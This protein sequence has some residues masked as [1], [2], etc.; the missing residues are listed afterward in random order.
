M[1]NFYGISETLVKV[2]KDI[3]E[4]M[5]AFNNLYTRRLTE[6]IVPI[7]RIRINSAFNSE[8]ESNNLVDPRQNLT[9]SYRV[10]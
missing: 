9:V 2:R 3:S 5:Q 1:S 6:L 4:C 7:I 10:L 8:M